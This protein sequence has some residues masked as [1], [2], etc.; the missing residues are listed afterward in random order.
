M[1]N[2][3]LLVEG[4]APPFRAPSSPAHS[5][6]ACDR[7]GS[8]SEAMDESTDHDAASLPHDSHCLYKIPQEREANIGT[9]PRLTPS[10]HELPR[11]SL[12]S[13]SCTVK[14]STADALALDATP[15]HD[16][17]P[18]IEAVVTLGD[19]DQI[20][21]TPMWLRRRSLFAFAALFVCLAVSL[22]V[23][24]AVDNASGG[25]PLVLSTYHYVWTYSPTAIL[26]CVIALWRQVD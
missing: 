2:A 18:A 6:V 4:A 22:I 14:T 8:R 9:V 17:G 24:W 20:Y 21:W 12:S 26:V 23:L 3:P 19:S 5:V 25:F 1:E 7:P 15:S 11:A 10:E 13:T 16:G